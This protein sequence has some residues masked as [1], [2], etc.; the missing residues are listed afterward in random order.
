MWPIFGPSYNAAVPRSHQMWWNFFPRQPQ[1]HDMDLEASRSV[2]L[3]PAEEEHK[4][5]HALTPLQCCP[6]L[7]HSLPR[8]LTQTTHEPGSS[9]RKSHRPRLNR[10]CIDDFRREA[11][12]AL[13]LPPAPKHTHISLSVQDNTFHFSMPAQTA[14]H[15]DCGALKK[16]SREATSQ[17]ILN[18]WESWKSTFLLAQLVA[19]FKSRLFCL[20]ST[21]PPTH[22]WPDMQ[23]FFQDESPSCLLRLALSNPMAVSISFFPIRC[24]NCL[25]KIPAGFF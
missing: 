14:L 9:S 4:E 13:R 5:K 6:G 25:L 8:R 3:T 16:Q 7:L 10:K 23:N 1:L 20:S 21:T 2:S 22:P 12:I 15:L 19:C 18:T 11:C 17:L 24:W